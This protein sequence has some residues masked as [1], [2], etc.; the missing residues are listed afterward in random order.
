MPNFSFVLHY[1]LPVRELRIVLLSSVHRLPRTVLA[2]FLLD[3][4]S[5][6]WHAHFPPHG[7]LFHPKVVWS[8]VKC[9][10]PFLS[11]DASNQHN[12][13]WRITFVQDV[14]THT[15][16]SLNVLILPKKWCIVCPFIEKRLVPSNMNPL[17]CVLNCDGVIM[18]SEI[19]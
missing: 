7:R 3:K 4:E 17:G 1:P 5:H 19:G 2:V 11:V 18:R 15:V 9:I 10:S 8:I 6:L 14:A 13:V 12:A 16:Y